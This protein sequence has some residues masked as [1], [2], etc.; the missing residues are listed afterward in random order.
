VTIVM[1][2]LN[3]QTA[4]LDLRERFYLSRDEL[5]RVLVALHSEISSEVVIV[6]TCNRL[7]I[8]TNA[9]E[10][11]AE[12]ITSFLADRASLSAAQ[13]E[14]HLQI[15][16]DH[17]AVQHLM[18]VAAGVESLVLGESEILGQIADALKQAQQTGTA[19]AIVSRLFQNAIHTGKR[20]RTETAIS[21]HTLS[22]SHAAVLMAKQQIPDLNRAKT[23]IIGAGRMAEQAARALKAYDVKTVRVMNRTFSRA[24]TLANRLNI[25]A[26]DW[27]DLKNALSEADLVITVTS[28]PQPILNADD[29]LAA[30]ASCGLVMVDIAVP[31]NVNRN[32]RDLPNV[33]LYDIDD[34]QN[35][36]D[37]HRAM[38]QSEVV[39]VEAIIAEELDSYLGWLNSRNAVPTIVALR[40][41]AEEMAA[42]ELE[43]ALH[44]LPDLS[45][46]EREVITQMAHR[47]VNK[48]LHAPTTALH[49]RA[50]QG[51][52]Y[53]YL[54]AARQLFDLENES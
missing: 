51:N 35:V 15:L 47:I 4:P 30:H 28:A 36:V 13:L 52:H 7:E 11:S 32:V 49:E 1:T 6:S 38:R 2:G 40:Q 39:R 44:R 50:T 14:S 31:R 5:Q 23:L 25:E 45:E 27:A 42:L 24:N 10:Q 3:Y 20:A 21:Q 48:M 26:I 33:R 8:Y 9:V 29:I 19:N 17:D 12:K 16:T 53:I 18:R 37:D 41:K 46:Q 54:H 34:L 22:V 43:R